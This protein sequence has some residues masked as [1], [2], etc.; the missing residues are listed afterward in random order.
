MCKSCPTNKISG[1]MLALGVC[2]S[3]QS[4]VF[5]GLTGMAPKYKCLMAVDRVKKRS[6]C[7]CVFDI[8][9]EQRKYVCVGMCR[10]GVSTG[11]SNVRRWL[12]LMEHQLTLEKYSCQ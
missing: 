12:S 10:W 3:L 6:V 1:L 7:F 8:G 9:T 4:V 5:Y 2:H 11:G